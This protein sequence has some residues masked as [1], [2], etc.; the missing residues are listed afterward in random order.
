MKTIKY[1]HFPEIVFLLVSFGLGI[2]LL[3]APFIKNVIPF[4]NN[5]MSM[6]APLV[7]GI[8]TITLSILVVHFSIT[9]QKRQNKIIRNMIKLHI[10]HKLPCEISIKDDDMLEILIASMREMSFVFKFK[11][12]YYAINHN[13]CIR[14]EK[15]VAMDIN[16][17][18]G[19]DDATQKLI[20]ER[21]AKNEK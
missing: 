15:K 5:D 3:I 10:K 7:S 20:E 1:L 16:T 12:E 2:F 17:K 8:A 19:V 18:G 9:Q 14:I 6:T 4:F 11:N 13:G 21:N